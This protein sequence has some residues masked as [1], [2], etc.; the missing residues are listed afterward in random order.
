M[1]WPYLDVNNLKVWP[2]KREDVPHVLIGALTK[3]GKPYNECDTEFSKWENKDLFDRLTH[4]PRLDLPEAVLTE[5]YVAG[6]KYFISCSQQDADNEYPELNPQEVTTLK[7]FNPNAPRGDTN[8]PILIEL[9]DIV[10]GKKWVGEHSFHF[11]NGSDSP[12]YTLLQA[13]IEHPEFDPYNICSKGGALAS[14]VFSYINNSHSKNQNGFIMDIQNAVI[15]ARKKPNA[16]ITRSLEFA[17]AEKL[18][19]GE[20]MQLN[21]K[22][23]QAVS[24][25]ATAGVLPEYLRMDV[26]AKDLSE[27]AAY[28]EVLAELPA[29]FKSEFAVQL[30]VCA[31]ALSE[32]RTKHNREG[33]SHKPSGFM[34]RLTKKTDG[35]VEQER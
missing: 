22:A 25:A 27:V 35:T 31:D 17:F 28:E 2:E 21:G 14:R 3:F 23:T 8:D 33:G 16:F 7:N 34:A 6:V 26:W 24:M 1:I 20:I 5:A 19:P 9:L 12:A 32:A 30:K 10:V 4:D 18:R 11:E 13:V 15:E 29:R